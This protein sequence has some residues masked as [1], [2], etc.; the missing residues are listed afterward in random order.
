MTDSL[1]IQ[2][3][4]SGFPATQQPP[5]GVRALDAK[6]MTIEHAVHADFDELA[7]LQ[8][9]WD[10]FIEDF[11]GDLFATYDWCRIWWK[12]YGAGRR[13]E[14][15]LF[16]SNDQIIGILPLFH[17]TLRIGPVAARLIR[18][19]G[20]DHSVTT[21]GFVVDPSFGERIASLLMQRLADG[22]RWDLLHF[23]PLPGYLEK[24]EEVG[25]WFRGRPGVRSVEITTE[26]EPHIVFDLPETFDAY[27]ETV[28]SRKRGQVRS[29]RKRL[30]K[31]GRS[32]EGMTPNSEWKNE[33]DAFIDQHQRQWTGLGNLG[34]FGD[35]PESEAFH[36][37]LADTMVRRGRFR[38]FRMKMDD[39]AVGYQYN[40]RFGSRAHW[41]I[42]SR[43]MDAKW[44]AFS[45]GRHLLC[46]SIESLIAEGV[47]QLD[48]MRGMYD[49]K[50]QLGGKVL[51]LQSISVFQRGFGSAIRVS[52]LRLAV[53]TLHLLYYRIWFNRLLPRL[54]IRRKPLARFWIRSRFEM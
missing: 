18:L 33:F 27:L 11:G 2:E 13:L 52:L 20:C 9:R 51:R 21:T 36:R 40:Y 17:E 14:I 7:E 15:H 49:Y 47:T 4:A 22:V 12:Y 38:L 50:L 45:L 23:G 39:E 10:R 42:G 44:D 28:A 6:S 34:H 19:V 29:T 54:P 35:W 46:S 48:G 1:Q 24:I 26:G 32:A 3:H 31:S 53:W 25:S 8:P 37:E 30:E 5:A 16:R 43:E 41:I